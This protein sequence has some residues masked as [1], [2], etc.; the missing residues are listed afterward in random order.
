MNYQKQYRLLIEKRK[1]YQL[2]REPYKHAMHHIFPKCMG[3][4]N[5]PENLVLLTHKEHYVAHH[6]LWKI[7]GDVMLTAFWYMTHYKN[8]FKNGGKLSASGYEK[9]RDANRLKTSKQISDRNRKMW[10]N[11]DYRKSQIKRFK[12]Y[13]IDPNNYEKLNARSKKLSLKQKEHFKNE[14]AHKAVSAWISKRNK[15]RKWWNNGKQEK[16]AMESPGSDWVLGRLPIS[17]AKL[18]NGCSKYFSDPINRAKASTMRAGIKRDPALNQR[19]IE[20]V[21]R[22]EVRKKISNSLIKYYANRKKST[23]TM[24]RDT[25]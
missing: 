25:K 20:V 9:L 7:Y 10:Q 12:E 17:I 4:L 8:N 1:R 18:C 13:F 3:G 22:P 2:V 5:L 6:L 16:F 19:M 14:S 23:A 21:R 11:I 24:Q 15:G